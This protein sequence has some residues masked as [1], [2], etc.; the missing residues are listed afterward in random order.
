MTGLDTN[1]LVRFVVQDDPVQS[2]QAAAFIKTSCT[3]VSVH[4]VKYEQPPSAGKKRSK[5]GIAI[6]LVLVIVTRNRPR[7]RPR[8]GHSQSSLVTHRRHRAHH[9][10]RDL[11]LVAGA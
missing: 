1:V 10:I 8:N 3:T 6:V 7:N 2:Q 5:T 9:R 11:S 4:R